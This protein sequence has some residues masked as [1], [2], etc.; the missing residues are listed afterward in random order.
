MSHNFSGDDPFPF[1]HPNDLPDLETLV[2]KLVHEDAS[3]PIGAY[4]SE[5]QEY[6]AHVLKAAC[7]ECSGTGESGRDHMGVPLECKT[8]GG[9]RTGS[10]E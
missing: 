1:Q 6:I 9:R 5:E 10:Y 3:T 8:C 7:P 4:T 2:W